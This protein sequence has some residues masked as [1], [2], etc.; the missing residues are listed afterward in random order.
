[1][2]D[3]ECFNH[4]STVRNSCLVKDNVE[5]R[6]DLK[7]D[8]EILWSSGER[9]EYRAILDP[10]DAWHP[11]PHDAT[12]TNGRQLTLQGRESGESDVGLSVLVD[13]R[14]LCKDPQ[15]VPFGMPTPIRLQSF[16]ARLDSV[17]Q[18][19][20]LSLPVALE[21]SRVQ[22]H[23]K[24][25]ASRRI[26]ADLKRQ[27]VNKVIEGGADVVDDVANHQT[28]LARQGLRNDQA[29]RAFARVRV[30]LGYKIV[31]P[32]RS[33]HEVVDFTLESPY[34]LVSPR[35]SKSKAPYRVH[36]H[37]S[38]YVVSRSGG[39]FSARTTRSS[40]AVRGRLMPLSSTL[41]L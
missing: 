22:I 36:L 31:R 14:K 20:N 6:I 18:D 2:E 33:E 23:G 25:N 12:D 32:W 30:I 37:K 19:T 8:H 3:V 26:G 11:M 39:A 7:V 13:I 29:H 41:T 38:A 35:E 21:V 17:G 1:M 15:R 4:R 10:L 28:P 34:V 24:R 5:R 9:G 40:V 16:D 27:F